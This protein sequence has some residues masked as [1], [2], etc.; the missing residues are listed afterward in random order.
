MLGKGVV[1]KGLEQGG[2]FSIGDTPADDAAAED[3]ED[4]V[5]VE[6]RPFG[7][8]HQLG[9]IPRPDLVGGFGQQLRLLVDGMA[10]LVAA[11]ADLALFGQDAI[12]GADRAKID[13]FVQ[14]GGIDL[15]GG[16]IDEPGGSQKIEHPSAFFRSKGAWRRAPGRPRS[17]RPE[18]ACAGAIDAGTCQAESGTGACGETAFASQCDSCLH[19]GVSSFSD[20]AIGIPSKAA[21]F[22]SRPANCAAWNPRRKRPSSEKQEA[23]MARTSRRERTGSGNRAVA[24]P[25]GVSG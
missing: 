16:Q 21:T 11:F 12:Q 4:N 17:G 14:Q 25:D 6:I 19:H 5:Q 3:V 2:V 15:R 7:R 23:Q 1:K 18:E 13:A 20:V 8:S 24:A 10:E 9:D 22:F